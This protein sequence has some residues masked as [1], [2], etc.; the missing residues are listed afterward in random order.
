MTTD[1]LNAMPIA[2]IRITYSLDDQG[3]PNV[4]VRHDGDPDKVTLLG[5]LAMAQDTI[6]QPE[7][8]EEQTP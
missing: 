7:Y 4:G 6:M 8:D 1:P 2:E 5:M 3:H